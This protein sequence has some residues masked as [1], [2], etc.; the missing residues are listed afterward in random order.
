MSEDRS[1]QRSHQ[2]RLFA[3]VFPPLG[4]LYQEIGVEESSCLRIVSKKQ[5]EG[6]VDASDV[7]AEHKNPVGLLEPPSTNVATYTGRTPSTMFLLS[8]RHKDDYFVVITVP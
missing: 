2:E 7:C 5:D 3:A 6:R 8:K 4:F 1:L